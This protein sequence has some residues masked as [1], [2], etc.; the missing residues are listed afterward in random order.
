MLRRAVEEE[1]TE[2]ITRAFEGTFGFANVKEIRTD[3]G[4]EF[5]GAFAEK[6]ADA[7]VAVTP[8]VVRRPQ[9]NSR[10]ERFH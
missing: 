9:T 2:G 1:R 10:A 8:T 6:A 3:P 4:T 5:G 7:S